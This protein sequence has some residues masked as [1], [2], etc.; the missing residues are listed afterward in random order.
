MGHGAKAYGHR[1][2]VEIYR[3]AVKHS[4]SPIDKGIK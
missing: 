4:A 1:P 2:L 3:A